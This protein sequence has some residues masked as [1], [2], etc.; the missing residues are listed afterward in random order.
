MDLF[1]RENNLV[2]AV[3]GRS[4]YKNKDFDETSDWDLG[5][6]LPQ[7][8]VK[9][10]AT[11]NKGNQAAGGGNSRS[12][13]FDF[14]PGG[15]GFLP[16]LKRTEA[17]LAF[18]S[19]FYQRKLS[20]MFYSYKYIRTER[21][22]SH[23]TMQ[24]LIPHGMASLFEGENLEKIGSS[25]QA[26]M[27]LLL[28]K[29]ERDKAQ[30]NRPK[31][32]RRKKLKSQVQNNRQTK[33]LTDRVK[34]AQAKVHPKAQNNRRK[35]KPAKAQAKA[36]AKAKAQNGGWIEVCPRKRNKGRQYSRQDQGR[37]LQAK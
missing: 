26:T 8:W 3:S 32:G 14:S 2:R 9:T 28:E 25:N 6:A 24:R 12:R 4:E 5:L 31:K 15:G 22:M 11:K 20:L 1:H 29:Q 19:N 36:Q 23:K 27:N 7:A 35:G 13:A 33:S 21:V 37:W 10:L 34:E 17:I 30:N 16:V 18:L